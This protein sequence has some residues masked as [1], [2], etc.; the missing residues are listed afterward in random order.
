VD[1]VKIVA[2]DDK[3]TGF[4]TTDWGGKSGFLMPSISLFIFGRTGV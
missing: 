4:N 1:K 2:C 3:N